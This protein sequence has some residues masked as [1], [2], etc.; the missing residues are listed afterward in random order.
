MTEPVS[1]ESSDECHGNGTAGGVRHL[2]ES[3]PEPGALA[4][5]RCLSQGGLPRKEDLPREGS[6]AILELSAVSQVTRLHASSGN[7]ASSCATPASPGQAHS[8]LAPVF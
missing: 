3:L 1:R 8:R 7:T 5:K 4:A 2:P 6:W